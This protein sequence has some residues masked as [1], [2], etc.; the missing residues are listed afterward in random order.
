MRVTAPSLAAPAV[1]RSADV[2]AELAKGGPH[3]AGGLA[4]IRVRCEVLTIRVEVRDLHRRSCRSRAATL[5]A[6]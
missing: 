4:S 5:G 3:D 1:A 6:A 2:V